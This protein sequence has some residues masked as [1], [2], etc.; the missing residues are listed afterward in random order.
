MYQLISI[1]LYVSTFGIFDV[2]FFCSLLVQPKGITFSLLQIPF[3]LADGLL[4]PRLA[5]LCL[6]AS[7]E[8]LRESILDTGQRFFLNEISSHLCFWPVQVL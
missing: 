8:D 4:I 3:P 7:P 2:Q 6:R 1:Y 5:L